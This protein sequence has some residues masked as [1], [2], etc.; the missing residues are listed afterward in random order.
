M[1]LIF[2]VD[3][4]TKTKIQ[5]HLLY[6]FPLIMVGF[7]C[8][9]MI[10]VNTAVV[11]SLLLQGIILIDDVNLSLLA[12]IILA[13]L[14]LPSNVMLAYISRIARANFLEVSHLAAF[15][16]LTGLRNRLSFES[17]LDTEIERQRH[18]GGIWVVI[19]VT[20]S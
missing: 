15:D 2:A 3:M 14:V 16:R 13:V 18:Y 7:H 1:G 12:K 19:K 10:L 8:Q 17:I 20:L 9:R 6:I 11:L 5:I 4:I